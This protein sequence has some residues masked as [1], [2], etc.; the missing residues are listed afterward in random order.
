M[1][2]LGERTMLTKSERDTCWSWAAPLLGLWLS[3]GPQCEVGCLS[4]LSGMR[5][6]YRKGEPLESFKWGS[7]SMSLCFRKIPESARLKM[8]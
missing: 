2:K 8:D 1:R 6:S 7:D 4:H 3:C 5:P